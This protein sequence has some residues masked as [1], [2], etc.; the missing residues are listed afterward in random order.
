MKKTIT[1]N[2][3]TAIISICSKQIRVHLIPGSPILSRVRT[4]DARIS[5]EG[6]E[7]DSRMNIPEDNL[8]SI[9]KELEDNF[10]EGRY[11]PKVDPLIQ[12][13]NDIGYK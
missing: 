10:L 2:G 11:A 6:K 5:I 3:E 1:H 8:T 4:W 7:V 13:L 12:K 9:L